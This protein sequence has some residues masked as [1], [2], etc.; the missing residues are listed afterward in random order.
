MGGVRLLRVPT[1]YF[2]GL[3]LHVIATRHGL[4]IAWALSGAK[5]D[6]RQVF[7]DMAG[8]LPPHLTAA[9]ATDGQTTMG[10][11]NYFGHQF[12]QRLNDGALAVLR[13]TR[14][15]EKARPGNELFK[16]SHRWSSQKR[17]V[18]TIGL[19]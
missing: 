17:T 4:P 13:P 10:D 1:R 19:S 6:E 9:I 16:R 7:E 12:G 15:G 11:K 3:R 8:L 18:S 5:A 2:W 14:R